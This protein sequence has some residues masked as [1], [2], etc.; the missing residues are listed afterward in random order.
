MQWNI[1]GGIVFLLIGGLA[2]WKPGLLWRLTEQ[3]K[4]YAADE[5]S[6]L[7]IFSTKFGAVILMVLG[8]AILALP[9]LP[10]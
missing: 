10:D 3:W 9:F 8:A 1:F 5:P 2:F 4:S 6:G 7:Y